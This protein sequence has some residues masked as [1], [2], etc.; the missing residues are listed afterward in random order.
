MGPNAAD[1]RKAGEMQDDALQFDG[2]EQVRDAMRLLPAAFLSL[3]DCEALAQDV[4]GRVARYNP[5]HLLAGFAFPSLLLHPTDSHPAFIEY[6]QHLILTHSPAARPVDATEEVVNG[7]FADVKNIFGAVSFGDALRNAGDEPRSELRHSLAMD[8]LYIRGKSYPF[9]QFDLLERLL[10][11]VDDWLIVNMQ[12]AASDIRRAVRHLY[13]EL[14][15]KVNR[16][17]TDMQQVESRPDGGSFGMVMNRDV[18]SLVSP[19]D[20]VDRALRLLAAAPGSRPPPSSLL[21]GREWL[22]RATSQFWNLAAGS[23]A[24]TPS[25][26]WMSCRGWSASGLQRVISRSSTGTTHGCAKTC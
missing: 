6:L 9:H 7:L 17:I 15:T 11:A 13:E 10:G 26:S 5:V 3:S 21:P 8:A 20:G 1:A 12:V 14:N 4:A 25:Q 24:S 23:T 2:K 18:F 19:D 16:A 22:H